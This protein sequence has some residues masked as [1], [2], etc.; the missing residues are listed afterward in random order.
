MI[1]VFYN[2]TDVNDFEHDPEDKLVS[3]IFTKGIF[4]DK[5]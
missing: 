5:N 1:Q 2:F 4:S 3:I